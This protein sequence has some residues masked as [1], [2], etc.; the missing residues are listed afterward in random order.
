[1]VLTQANSGLQQLSSTALAMAR[2]VDGHIDQYE[3]GTRRERGYMCGMSSIYKEDCIEDVATIA[4]RSMQE[5]TVR[6]SIINGVE[7][8]T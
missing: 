1:M 3:P 7:V 4:V 2:L 8:F 5:S 6:I